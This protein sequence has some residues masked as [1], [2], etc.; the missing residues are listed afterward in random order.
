MHIH[1]T[2]TLEVVVNARKYLKN[3]EELILENKIEI[4]FLDVMIVYF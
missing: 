1:M 3:S 4:S 2:T